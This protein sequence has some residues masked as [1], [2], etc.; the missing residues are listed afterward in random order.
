MKCFRNT[1]LLLLLLTLNVTAQELNLAAYDSIMAME[2]SNNE[3]AEIIE[4]LLDKDRNVAPADLSAI[5]YQFSK[6]FWVRA[7]WDEKKAIYYG[8]KEY[9]LRSENKDLNPDHLKRNLYNLG[10]FYHHATI[11]DYT[12]ALLRFNELARLSEPSEMRLG[13]TFREMGDIYDEL[14]DFKRALEYYASSERVLKKNDARNRL[15]TTY[16]NVSATYG[17]LGDSLYFEAFMDNYQ[18]IE[19][20]KKEI[21]ISTADQTKLLLNQGVMYSTI[22]AYDKANDCYA[23]ALKLAETDS[24]SVQVFKILNALGVLN[25]KQ[26]RYDRAE[27]LHKRSLQYIKGDHDYESS[28]YNNLAD[29]F[30]QKSD[31]S[32]ALTHYQ[33]ALNTLLF[34]KDM[35][36]TELPDFK[37][38]EVSPYKKA[39]LIF[40][41]DKT[42]AWIEYYKHT[43]NKE[44]LIMAEETMTLV[45][46]LIDLLYFE[47]REELS[48]LFWRKK[49]A[50]LYVKAVTIC[51]E[52][53]K[54]GKAFYYMEKN[55]GLLL[56]ENISNTK[57]RQ[58]GSI[59]AA[60]IDKEY[61][62]LS[63][64]KDLEYDL[65]YEGRPD[66][67]TFR[68]KDS[69]QTLIFGLKAGYGQFVDSLET[70]FPD[71]YGF[72]KKVNILPLG[73]AIDKLDADEVVIEYIL[74]AEEGYVIYISKQHTI[75]KKISE[76]S[77][78]TS[79]VKQYYRQLS[80]PFITSTDKLAHEELSSK[81]LNSILPFDGLDQKLAGKKL[82]IVPDRILQHIPFE[83][84][85]LNIDGQKAYLIGHSEVY[86]N[87]SLSLQNQLNALQNDVTRIM[88]EFAIEDFRDEYLP[89]LNGQENLTGLLKFDRKA[90]ANSEATKQAFLDQYN[91]SSIVCVSTHGGVDNGQPW[92]GF[93]DE[94]LTL[95]ELYFTPSQKEMVVLSACK[96]SVGDYVEGESVYN[97][98]RGFINSGAKSVI[99][100]LWNANEQSSN[101][102]LTDFYANLNQGQ[103]KSE[104]LKNAKLTYLKTHKNSS[105]ASPYYWSSIVLTGNPE[106]LIEKSDLWVYVILGALLILLSVSY[107]MKQKKAGV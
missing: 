54:P 76:V 2:I 103:T 44:H 20:L 24:D 56:L 90:F 39:I 53:N 98:S 78:L 50:E 28:I 60:V 15:L 22:T 48:K 74:G 95:D 58:Y 86:Y 34:L 47:S 17:N 31:H 88:A 97:L 8:E 4:T 26:K 64:I 42:N 3:K 35:P 45:D 38:I 71:Y 102:I 52:L 36:Y 23:K 63:R 61:D 25:K 46:R 91:K 62:M 33:K 101:A 59:P 69:L 21:S 16:I 41:I 85:L 37:V 93:Y 70:H 87:Y 104:A 92:L 99:A 29:L 57:A 107:I 1:G 81:L 80:S 106:I 82:N 5:Y 7:D 77:Q 30:L 94:K 12:N 84:L 100:T 18:K 65:L 73:E 89:A 40:L 96:T 9:V 75:F 67:S 19:Q 83:T 10:F 32:N 27:A 105:E 72:K 79:D 66:D 14:G 43:S 51:Y 11:P 55:K 68:T 49:G 6:W 13:N